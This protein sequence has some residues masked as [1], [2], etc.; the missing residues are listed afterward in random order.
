MKL[1]LWMPVTS[2][3][4]RHFCIEL[5]SSMGSSRLYHYVFTGLGDRLLDLFGFATFADI[6]GYE[7][8]FFG[9]GRQNK[10]WDYDPSLFSPFQRLQIVENIPDGCCRMIAPYGCALH[11]YKIKK[12]VRSHHP[13]KMNDV[14]V[15]SMKN[16]YLMYAR[17]F[18]AGCLVL[19]HMP[20]GIGD[21]VGIHL[22][23]SDKI[24]DSNS[25]YATLRTDFDIIVDRVKAFVIDLLA[26]GQN[27]FYLCSEDQAWKREFQDWLEGVGGRVTVNCESPGEKPRGFHAVLDFFCLSECKSI[28]QCINYS[29]FSMA[30][31]MVGGKPLHNFSE[32]VKSNKTHFFNWWQPL[33][34]E[35][36]HGMIEAFERVDPH[37]G[38]I[39]VKEAPVERNL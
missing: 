18:K 16:R 1:D 5:L 13:N 26:R 22:R 32:D 9:F 21:C 19:N 7:E 10:S 25:Y 8:V 38:D 12:Y 34:V 2:F 36:C 11:P 23:K 14:S 20:Q 3:L 15:E 37:I 30:A 29:T 4:G 28:V 35:D 33:L 17:S 39:D 27:S 31:A 24:D 6:V